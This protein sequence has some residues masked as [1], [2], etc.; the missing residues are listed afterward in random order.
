MRIA[1]LLLLMI[2]LIFCGCKNSNPSSLQKWKALFDYPSGSGIAYFDKKIYLMGDDAPYLLIMDTAFNKMDTIQF[3]HSTEKRIPKN[4]KSDP[5]AIAVVTIDTAQALLIMG[6]GS[7]GPERS[8]CWLINTA[9]KE[10]T[11]IKLDT[12]YDRLKARGIKDLNIEGAAE[13]P[14]G[15]VLASRG[16]KSYPK[17]HLIFTSRKFW[18]NQTNANI[19]IIKMGPNKDTAVFTGVSGLEYSKLTDKL[20]LTIS[21]EETYNSQSDGIIGKS[22]IWLINDISSKM[23]YAGINPD[24]VIDLEDI[25][26]KFNKQKIESVCI[27]SEDKQA[28]QLALVADDDKGGSILFTIQ[29][30][31]SK[32]D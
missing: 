22:Y 26:P 14:G 10:K 2:T 29:L 3:L 32:K 18:L 16:N 4:I 9:T 31:G 8:I 24:Q 23:N 12:F 28:V 20:L 21:T 1:C 27:I 6:S 30:V 7:L 11:I 5:E 17:N 13:I 25:D 19:N 15:I